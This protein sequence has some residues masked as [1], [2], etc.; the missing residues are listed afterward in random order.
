LYF[1]G[2]IDD[3]EPFL[4]LDFIEIVEELKNDGTNNFNFQFLQ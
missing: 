2:L 1:V 3:I 4:Y